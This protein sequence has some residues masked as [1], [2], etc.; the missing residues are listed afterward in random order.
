MAI[1]GSLVSSKNGVTYTSGGGDF[2]HPA[3]AYLNNLYQIANDGSR[4]AEFDAWKQQT[5]GTI[6]WSSGQMRE[7]LS[8]AQTDPKIKQSLSQWAMMNPTFGAAP[9]LKSIGID[10]SKR[11]ISVPSAGVLGF[12]G[13]TPD[14]YVQ[15]ELARQT[16][17]NTSPFSGIQGNQTSAPAGS[18]WSVQ[19]PYAQ[20]SAVGGAPTFGGFAGT[21]P[22]Q[23]SATG[24]AAGGGSAG[25]SAGG[26]LVQDVNVNQYQQNP[27]LQ[28]MGTV[29]TNRVT[30]NLNRNIMPGIRSNAIAAGGFGGS[31]QG[32]VEANA[33][34]DANQTISDALTG[35]YFG[36]FTN[37]MNRNLQQYGQNQSFYNANRGMDLQQTQLGANLWQMGNQGMLGQGQ[38]IY[39]LG[40]QQQQ[41]PWQI[42]NNANAGLGQWSGY[43]TTTSANQG[44]GAQGMLGGALAG[45]QLG[46]LWGGS[47]LGT[48]APTVGS[49][50][51]TMNPTA[52]PWSL[53][54]STGGN[55]GW[56]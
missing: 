54:Q 42:V 51:S 38:G 16:Q 14:K 44:G 45:G 5:G 21:A 37:Q 48:P 17:P 11:T 15:G 50:W 34:K 49:N 47:S 52:A 7:L 24:G 41:A 6:D 32:V 53:G 22:G 31:R 46:S 23:M 10:N 26:G 28:Q 33:M 8:L 20:P 12:L 55:G 27:Y 36:D 39:G 40:S 3:Q 35:A 43:G 18:T 1:T 19:Q 25:G 4:R 56:V 13:L 9:E 2:A 30:D 29:L